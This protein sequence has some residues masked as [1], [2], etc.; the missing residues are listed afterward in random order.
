MVLDMLRMQT[1]GAML[2]HFVNFGVVLVQKLT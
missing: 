2:L 1:L